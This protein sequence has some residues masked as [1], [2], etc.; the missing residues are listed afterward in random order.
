[1]K[2]EFIEAEKAHFPVDFM[3][4]QL[5]VSRSGYYAWK[6]R[7]ESERN[8]ADR[9]LAEVVTAVH[10]E[11]R[12]RYGSP[13]VHAELR[14][15]GQRVSRKRVAR[16]MRQHD[17]AARKRRRFVR[18]TDSRH[19]QPVAPNVLERNFS[20]GQPNSTWA[21]DIT[22]VG[23]RQGWLYLAVVLDLFSRKVV[24]W[25]MSEHIDRHLVLNAL[26]MALKGRQPPRGLLHH[27]DR[28][29][30]YASTDYQQALAARGIR[31]SMSRKGNCWDN[32]V[33]ESFF[34]SL[35]LELVYTTDFATHEQARLAL[36]EY[37]EVFYNRQRRHS[38]LGYVSPVDFELAALP[39]KLAS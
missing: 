16:L 1:V 33:V 10:Q 18:T 21:T 14:A 34:S 11:S 25:S 27:S 8:K 19:T 36:F 39:Q 22:Y 5:G 4:Q 15:R 12:G 28:G 37:I 3:C 29:S 38:S 2:F 30:Q 9:A 31:C 24:G 17:I 32:A 7:P 20:P 26:D 23:T 35:K 6:E 13:R